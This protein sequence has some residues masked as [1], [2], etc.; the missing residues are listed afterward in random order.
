LKLLNKG[1]NLYKYSV[2]HKE[3]IVPHNKMH[4]PTK[5]HFANAVSVE[6][7]SSHLIR[8]CLIIPR[9]RC[10]T[11]HLCRR[12][13]VCDILLFWFRRVL[14]LVHLLSSCQFRSIRTRYI[15]P[16]SPIS[17]EPA[18]YQKCD[19]SHSPNGNASYRTSRKTR[20]M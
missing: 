9:P 1:R 18:R 10:I 14:V 20:R 11:T 15:L 4:S 17:K 7:L 12:F 16:S 8:C 13:R 3:D 2:P 19:N 6:L 5:L